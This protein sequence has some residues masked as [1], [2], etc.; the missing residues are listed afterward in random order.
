MSL[1]MARNTD[2][3]L[4]SLEQQGLPAEPFEDET[5][6]HKLRVGLQQATQKV[7]FVSILVSSSLA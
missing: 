2:S 5:T 3:L 6:H 1:M 7:H 4:E